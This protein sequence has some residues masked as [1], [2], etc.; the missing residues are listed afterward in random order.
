MAQGQYSPI[1]QYQAGR[2]MDFAV[3]AMQETMRASWDIDYLLPPELHTPSGMLTYFQ[4]WPLFVQFLDNQ[5]VHAGWFI[6]FMGAV[7]MNFWVHP[8][9]RRR[10][11]VGYFLFELLQG[12]FDHGV[13]AIIGW[14]QEREDADTTR[15]FIRLHEK[16]GYEYSGLMKQCFEGQDCHV[17]VLTPEG[18][19]KLSNSRLKHQWAKTRG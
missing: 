15:R 12:A 16:F 14:I 13:N 5:I 7:V 17:V 9:Y 1:V 4:N 11:D 10:R 18:F 19:D 6:P 3:L 8:D 2:D